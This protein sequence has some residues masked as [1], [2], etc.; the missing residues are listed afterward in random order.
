ML[1]KPKENVIPIEAADEQSEMKRVIMMRV[2]RIVLTAAI[3]L[4]SVL[5]LAAC[6]G[7]DSQ[8]H[9]GLPYSSVNFVKSVEFIKVAL[10]NSDTRSIN[11]VDLTKGQ[12][13]ANTVL[14]VT[15]SNADNSD[16]S[17]SYATTAFFLTGF[18]RRVRV[19]RGPEA[20]G[21]TLVAYIWA[22]EMDLSKVNVYQGSAQ[23]SP[24]GSITNVPIGNG[25]TVDLGKAFFVFSYMVAA[26]G[27]PTGSALQIAGQFLDNGT[28]NFNRGDTTADATIYWFVVEAKNNEF[29]TQFQTVAIPANSS[30]ATSSAFASVSTTHSML[31][32]SAWSTATADVGVN[33][34]GLICT[35]VGTGPRMGQ[36]YIERADVTNDT[37]EAWVFIVTFH[38]NELVNHGVVNSVGTGP[39]DTF[40]DQTGVD[41]TIS[42]PWNPMGVHP[43]E[44]KVTT[45]G[46]ISGSY[47][48]F[49]WSGVDI[50]IFQRGST[51]S[52]AQVAWEVVQW[53]F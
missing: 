16:K 4:L 8:E 49:S 10:H 17:D 46:L 13:A 9:S 32:G 14:F 35:P 24:G 44:S 53:N 12:I 51:N 25:V 30:N 50:D 26:A 52:P 2:K 22:V 33:R 21:I 7:E 23:I 11:D 31:I 28:L 39:H 5:S 20:E 3:C 41:T 43:S 34:H 6:N 40:V 29:T 45:Q 37:I 27:S 48:G 42:M 18:P 19:Q 36:I 47:A 38:G 15:L 1:E